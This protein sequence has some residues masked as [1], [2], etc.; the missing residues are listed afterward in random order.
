MWSWISPIA[1][2]LV[3]AWDNGSF[4]RKPWRTI[5]IIVSVLVGVMGITACVALIGGGAYG[6]YGA[7]KMKAYAYGVQGMEV[8][9]LL[10]GAFLIVGLLVARIWWLRSTDIESHTEG[11][12]VFIAGP[13]VAHVVRTWG[14]TM[15]TAS[16]LWGVLSFLAMWPAAQLLGSIPGLGPWLMNYVQP[17]FY[18]ALLAPVVAF[19]TIMI[20]RW[21]AEVIEVIFAIANNTRAL[22]HGPGNSSGPTEPKAILPPLPIDWT[23][24]LVG[25]LCYLL[26]A[27]SL[28][29][30]LVLLPTLVALILCLSKRW[31]HAATMF[32]A[33]GLVLVVRGIFELFAKADSDSIAHVFLS[34]ALPL[35]VI[36]LLLVLTAIVFLVM[37]YTGRLTSTAGQ[38]RAWAIG[39]SI[40]V[41]YMTD[42]GIRTIAEAMKRHELTASEL[43]V[44]EDLFKEYEGRKFGWRIGGQLDTTRTFMVEPP[45]I[46]AD[47][48]GTI[49][50]THTM[51]ANSGLMTAQFTCPYTVIKLPDSLSYS[52]VADVVMLRY[53][54]G[55]S[56]EFGQGANAH[57]TAIAVDVFEGLSEQREEQRL[58]E[59]NAYRDSLHQRLDTLTCT[60]VSYDC[61]EGTCFAWFDVSTPDGITRRSLYCAEITISGFPINALPKDGTAWTIVTRETVLAT[62]EAIAAGRGSVLFELYELHPVAQAVPEPEV[63]KPA[64]SVPERVTSPLTKKQVYSVNETDEPPL[65]PGGRRALKEYLATRMYP[66]AERTNG[67]VGEVKVQFVVTSTGSIDEVSVVKS[68]GNL[69]FD[70]EAVRLIEAMKR[71]TPGRK[72]NKAVDVRMTETVD[73]SLNE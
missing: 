29:E 4:F 31:M 46:E 65:Y 49:T 68:P 41:L 16:G 60:F 22:R 58:A 18:A 7:Y 43:Q 57:W 63:Q 37:E 2:R 51:N 24:I 26:I 35:L 64:P 33:V 12:K 1:D 69:G 61:T 27:L 38:G 36:L 25:C 70:R 53:L 45:R 52:R 6:C 34:A 15:G 10:A 71:W 5:Y 20:T 23:G 19:I 11:H 47:M 66:N 42:P 50:V 55:D 14:E 72:G 73:F 17:S 40:G 54:N 3:G 13:I 59:F 9:I 48:Y 21:I 56:I 32:V 39:M 62:Q 67:I 8:A 30:S 28:H 44:A